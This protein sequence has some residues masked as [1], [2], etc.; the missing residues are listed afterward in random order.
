MGKEVKIIIKSHIP[1]DEIET[2]AKC[3]LPDIL[4]PKKADKNLNSG[5]ESRTKITQQLD[6]RK[7]QAFL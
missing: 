3:F 7:L 2:L 1:E 4:N 5:K 6:S